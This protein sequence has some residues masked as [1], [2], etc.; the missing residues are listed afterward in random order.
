M[1]LIERCCLY[2][3]A[4]YGLPKSAIDRLVETGDSFY[5]PFCGGSQ[6]YSQGESEADKLRRHLNEATS[7]ASANHRE[8]EYQKRRA[9]SFKGHLTRY[10]R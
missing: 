4:I 1:V 10:R 2:C 7:R 6:H 3:K 9:A 5:C 8:A